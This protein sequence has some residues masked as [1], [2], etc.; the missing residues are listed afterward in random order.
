VVLTAKLDGTSPAGK[1]Q[2]TGKTGD[3]PWRVELDVAKASR[4]NGIA[5]LWA[6]RKIDDLEANAYAVNDGAALDKQIETVAL[7]H[8]LVSRVTSL[9]AVDVTPSR[10]AGEPVAST[11]V[12]LNLPQ[13][14]DFEKVFGEK[15]LPEGQRKASLDQAEEQA[16]LVADRMAAAPTARAAS[17]IAQA[18]NQVNLPQTATLADR[19]ILIGLMLLA[20]AVMAA[21]TFGLWRWQMRGLIL[22]ARS[23]VQ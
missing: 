15:M 23:R 4:G 1:L 14:W 5:K 22:E 9:V 7:A 6:R 12:P 10:P 17:L 16:M 21:S 18:G 2:I 19:Y 8:H 13:G 20:V 3:Q 11:D